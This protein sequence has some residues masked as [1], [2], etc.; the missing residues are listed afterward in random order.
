MILHIF[1]TGLLHT[2]AMVVACKS[3]RRAV[4]VDPGPGSFSCVVECVKKNKF[5]VDSIILTHS[6]WDHFSDASR[7]K[8]VYNVPLFVHAADADNLRNPG[9]DGLVMLS[10]IEAVEPDGL[11]SD[12]EN[13]TVGELEFRVVHTPGHSP[14]SVCFYCAEHSMILTGDTLFKGGIGNLSLPTS[15]PERMRKSL[16]TLALLPPETCVYPGHG[17]KTTIKAEYESLSF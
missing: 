4:I 3:T 13:I 6:H 15:Q 17:R 14:G 8:S 1:P 12:G 11:L 9:S 10:D 2:N 7:V 16:E 5:F